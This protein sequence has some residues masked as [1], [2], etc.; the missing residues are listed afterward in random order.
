MSQ[1]LINPAPLIQELLPAD[2]RVVKLC[3]YNRFPDAPKSRF[4]DGYRKDTYS[5][6]EKNF[7]SKLF[8]EHDGV[9][10]LDYSDNI[11]EL[12]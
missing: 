2:K 4:A 5:V 11:M 9:M 12:I 8:V 3:Y 1:I 10:I 6:I 7:L